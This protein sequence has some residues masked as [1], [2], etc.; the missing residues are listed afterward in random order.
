MQLF[1][2]HILGHNKMG[3]QYRKKDVRESVPHCAV[4]ESTR[5]FWESL[6]S[7]FPPSFCSLDGNVSNGCIKSNDLPLSYMLIVL[8]WPSGQM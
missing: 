8:P 3:A 5:P 2:A 1:S 4:L 6:I 7:S